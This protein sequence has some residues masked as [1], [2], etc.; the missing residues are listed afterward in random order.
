MYRYKVVIYYLW[1]G[2]QKAFRKCLVET[3]RCHLV[4]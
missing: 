3:R 1:E 4:F 2:N